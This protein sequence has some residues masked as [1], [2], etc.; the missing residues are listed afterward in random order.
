MKN[1]WKIIAVALALGAPSP[2]LAQVGG[3]YGPGP[4]PGCPLS[5]C[6]FTG[7]VTFNGQTNFPS[8]VNINTGG[9]LTMNTANIAQVG[10]IQF[11]ASNTGTL[12][13]LASGN[14]LQIG[15]ADAASPIAQTFQAQSVVAGNANTAGATFTIAGSKSNGSGGGDIV[16]QTTLSNAASGT[17]NTLATALTLKGGTQAA[18][19][20]G[21]I[22]AAN[23]ATSSAGTTGT[24][25]WTT[26]TGLFN[27]DTTTTCLLSLEELKDIRGPI[28]SAESLADVLAL[29]PFWG[30][31][32]KSTPEYAGDKAEQPFLGAHQVAS[33]DKRLAA[34]APNGA[35]HG[36]RYQELT[37]VLVGAIQFQQIEINILVAAI[38]GLLGWNIWLTIRKARVQR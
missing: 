9:T 4:V 25:C 21:V 5:G 16:F 12:V 27:V 34:Y 24:V 15:A 17:Q 26:G 13:S 28:S 18:V 32:K 6:T 1:P 19:F 8:S 3:P 35:L 14:G 33:V 37:A 29:K 36:V 2:V 23:L 30:T 7:A 11:G 20:S 10:R 38:L 22:N 31:W